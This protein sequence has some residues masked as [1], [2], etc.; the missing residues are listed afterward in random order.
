[1]H[2]AC[3]TT[4][5]VVNFNSPELN[6]LALAM[7]REGELAR[8]VRPYVNK[9]RAW[10]RALASVPIGRSLYAGS[11][12]RRRISDPELSRLTQEAGV[13]A[14]LCSA[15]IGRSALLP[16]A[17]RRHWANGL[18]MQ[19]RQAVAEAGARAALNVPCVVAY[20]GF[21]LPAFRAAARDGDAPARLVLNY[22]VAHHRQRR[23][24][25]AE[26]LARE[27]AF[28]STW[29]GFDDWGPG[30]EA[31]LDAE[32]DLADVVL[33]GS[34]FAADSF[35]LQGVPRHKLAV[36]PYG[37]DLEIFC[38][39]AASP[40][41]RPFQ[42]IYAGQLTQRKG[43]SYLLRGYRRFARPDSRLT[44]V[45]GITGS[46]EPLRP[47]A[48]LF[49]HVAHQ[50]RPALAER[51]RRSHV[52]VFPTL[53]E[54]MPLVVL[55]AMACGLPVIVTANGPGGIVRDGIDGFI[56]PQRDEE[57]VADRLDHLYRHP[58]LAAEMGRNAVARAREFSWD[59]YARRV[60]ACLGQA[61]ESRP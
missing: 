1:M 44:L 9:G 5:L 54:G 55:E 30:H 43:L 8:Y 45:G 49:T 59:V 4:A 38:P 10:E 3:P 36:I 14:D 37:V 28:A 61:L 27:P 15:V 17:W 56:I 16:T 57:A 34:D 53:V 52:F 51:Y 18:R 32:I 19:V 25:R 11:F 12:G 2:R 29:P 50:T 26:E 42:V 48:E 41:S 13:A 40:P 21:A 31:Q 20:E 60:R 23:Q 7:A 24:I 22:P 46:A 35:V 6:H 33:L 47:F 58:E 39:A